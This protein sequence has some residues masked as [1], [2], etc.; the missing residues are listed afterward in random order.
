MTLTHCQFCSNVLR[1]RRCTFG[2]HRLTEHASACILRS[3]GI[4]IKSVK[5]NRNLFQGTSLGFG[6][7]EPDGGQH[8]CKC[9]DIHKVELPLDRV[10]GDGVDIF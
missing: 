9:G 8:S 10:K 6:E 5:Y 1:F 3:M 2:V 7:E 4:C